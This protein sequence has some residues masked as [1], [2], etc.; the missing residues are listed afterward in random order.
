MI[1][2]MS[3]FSKNEWKR[4]VSE[5]IDSEDRKFIID[6]STKY[7]KIDTLSLECEDYEIKDYFFRLSLEESRVKF[8]E[9]SA[10]CLKTC[11]TVCPSD[12]ENIKP[13]TSAFI[14][15]T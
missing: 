11:R 15:L 8:R 5:K 3:K 4:F 1:T 6:W 7:K 9:H 13:T 14:A 12:I 10:G 2:D